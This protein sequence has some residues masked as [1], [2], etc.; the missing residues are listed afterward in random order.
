VCGANEATYNELQGYG[1]AISKKKTSFL[2]VTD[3]E[4]NRLPSDFN[5]E[6]GVVDVV[7]VLYYV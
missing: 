7:V 2:K 3:I 5:V 1:M 6:V 4:K